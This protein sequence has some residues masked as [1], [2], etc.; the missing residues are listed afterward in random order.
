MIIDGAIFDMDGT[1]LDS[2]GIWKT[3]TKNYMTG[4]GYTPAE[5]LDEVT[6]NMSLHQVACFCQEQYHMAEEIP[7]IMDG[8]NH[9]VEHFYLYEAQA[10]PGVPEFLERLRR[11]GVKMCL[12]T[13]TDLYL[14]EAALKRVG[15]RKYFEKLFTCTNIG[16]GK[17][18]PDI[19][20]AALRFMGTPR[21]TTWVF[22]DLLYALKTAK[23]AGFRTAG[24]Y[25]PAEN[26]PEEMKRLSDVYIT[27]FLKPTGFTA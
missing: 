20:N 1:L 18:E 25:D 21:S 15:I 27:S 22:E 16:H 12:A 23:T 19:Y 6:K 24:V 17:D 4:A 13:A 7:G 26:E 14:V 3:A 10:K 2:M 11:D 5:D 9:S 8:I